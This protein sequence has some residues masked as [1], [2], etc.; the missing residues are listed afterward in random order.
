MWPVCGLILLSTLALHAQPETNSDIPEPG[1][2]AQK[3][4]TNAPPS[5]IAAPASTN[6]PSATQAPADSSS[7]PMPT[8]AGTEAPAP[9]AIRKPPPV[10]NVAGSVLGAV[11]AFGSLAGFILYYCGLTRAKNSGHT[12][13]LLLVGTLVGLLGFW[14]GG[15]ALQCGGMGDAHAALMQS[16]DR[17]ATSGL[18]YEV[19]FLAFGHH[20]GLMGSTGFFL[21][22]D[23]AAARNSIAVLFLVQA[24]MVL[25]AIVAA[26]GAALERAKLLAMIF[27]AYL[28]GFLIY[29]LFANWAWGG[30]WLAGNGPRAS[31]RQRLRRSGRRRR[32]APDRRRARAGAGHRPRPASR[33][34]RAQ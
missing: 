30:G 32:R 34:L 20:W 18:D 14:I 29:P 21:A 17:S 12:V 15:F 1:A 4:A 10:W 25:I 6:A 23:D 16:P 19:G 26:L 28:V 8:Q 11:M 24:A 9:E 27:C 13:T 33:P 31:P 2:M 7:A 3:A 5:T 22:S